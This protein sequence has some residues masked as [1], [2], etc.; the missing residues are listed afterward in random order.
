MVDPKIL[1]VWGQY[2]RWIPPVTFSSSQTTLG[3]PLKPEHEAEEGIGFNFFEKFVPQGWINSGEFDLYEYCER[4]AL[5]TDF[6]FIIVFADEDMGIFPSNLS[7]FNC[8]VILLLADTHHFPRPISKL[9][10]YALREN[11]SM[12][13]DQFTPHHL[14]WFRK[15]GIPLCA[16][17]PGL[18]TR[19][20]PTQWETN[21]TDVVS[22]VG[23]ASDY[24][25]IRKKMLS[26]IHDAGIPL[27]HKKCTR[28]EAALIYST[29][30]ISFNCSLNSDINIRNFEVLG[31][32]GFLLADSLPEATGFSALFEPGEA[33]DVYSN[34]EEL[35]SKI[36]FYRQNPDAALK[37]AHCGYRR[38]AARLHPR[39]AVRKFR[40]V[41]FESQ[42]VEDLLPPDQ[43]CFE[44]YGQ[45]LS[46]RIAAY[47]DVQELHRTRT[48]VNVL[49]DNTGD[50]IRPSD[51]SDLSRV[52]V[53]ETHPGDD[54]EKVSASKDWDYIVRDE[55][56]CTEIQK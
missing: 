41:F 53:R 47:E 25:F 15:A 3:V 7:A 45:H 5:P 30:T 27:L 9:V 38:F 35:L 40:R 14:H 1:V 37:I 32:G 29:N 13:A 51:F 50:W 44:P 12:V 17:M 11:I 54:L 16:W 8:P 6:D 2:P 52:S 36:E 33:C 20:V 31:S 10:A 55:D 49:L 18:V 26:F 34:Q 21:R 19:D 22:F 43:R 28:E 23:H 42:L 56:K 24:H 48:S 39:Y 4:R 46:R